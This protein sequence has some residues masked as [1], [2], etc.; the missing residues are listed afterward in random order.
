[1]HGGY[2]TFTNYFTWSTATHFSTSDWT[3]E[4]TFCCICDLLTLKSVSTLTTEAKKRWCH[5]RVTPENYENIVY[6]EQA[7]LGT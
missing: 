3:V 1:M 5:S 2:G 6:R 4:G 7:H